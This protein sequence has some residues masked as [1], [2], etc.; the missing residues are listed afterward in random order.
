MAAAAASEIVFSVCRGRSGNDAHNEAGNGVLAPAEKAE[1]V[2]L[3]RCSG[4]ARSDGASAVGLAAAAADEIVVLLRRD[5]SGN[6]ARDGAGNRV[7][8]AASAADSAVLVWCSGKARSS[9]AGAVG[10]AAAAADKVVIS[11]CRGRS[12]NAAR[13]GAGNVVLVA[14]EA[15]VLVVVVWCSG[16]T[17]TD[18]AGPFMLA[19]VAL[20]ASLVLSR[21]SGASPAVMATSRAACVTSSPCSS[22]HALKESR[23]FGAAPGW[24]GVTSSSHP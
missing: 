10:F 4:R 23:A 15:A 8:V 16:W 18:E 22:I 5:G 14:A 2:V 6:A 13:D 20:G 11:V 24:V 3:V 1:S 19:T 7:L 9:R 12:G 21:F 17:R